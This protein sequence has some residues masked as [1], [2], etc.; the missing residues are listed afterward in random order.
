MLPN[1][2]YLFLLLGAVPRRY[3]AYALSV[4]EFLLI[5]FPVCSVL[6]GLRGGEKQP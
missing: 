6:R 4:V 5:V 1:T 3:F 2:G